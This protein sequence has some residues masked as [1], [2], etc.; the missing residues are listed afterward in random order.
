MRR[1][2]K[3]VAPSPEERLAVS[4]LQRVEARF[5]TG[6]LNAIAAMRRD[7]GSLREIARMIELGRVE[8]VLERAANAGAVRI[9]EQYAATYV[10]GGT[11]AAQNLSDVLKVTVAF[12][13]V[14]ERAVAHM[15]QERL[16]LIRGFTTEQRLATRSALT[17]GI[18]RG[19]NPRAQARL[20]RDTLGLTQRQQQT[21]ANYRR[22]LDRASDGNAEALTRALRDRR[23][24]PTI[25]NTLRTGQPIPRPQQDLMV[26]R[27]RSRMR[28]LRSETIAR[29][30]SLRAVHVAQSEAFEQAV[31]DR[32][33]E[34]EAV[35]RTWVA[36]SDD[37]TR[38]SHR[39]LNGMVRGM[40]E[41]FPGHLGELRHPGD[42]AAPGGET[43]NC[44][45][46]LAV[47][48]A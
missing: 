30:E 8:E 9:A 13:Q 19:L 22:L 31:E 7:A 44:R 42:P 5:R 10:A 1:V 27:Y 26:N 21:V 41:T 29:T 12:D 34:R 33:V 2:L 45:C 4:R 40:D 48:V 23:F 16:R 14:N 46:T 39:A 17:E 6:V 24:D 37:R 3:R 28:K 15:Q 43:I 20:F 32:V 25:R 35:R 11:A 18:E 36:A 47:Q 38:E